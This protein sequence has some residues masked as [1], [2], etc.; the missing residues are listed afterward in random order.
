MLLHAFG[1]LCGFA[2][3]VF[4]AASR[5][6]RITLTIAVAAAILT[7]VLLPAGTLPDPVWGALAALIAAGLLLWR[8]DLTG[9]A[10]A[11]SGVA[12]AAWMSLLT[13][14]GVP[15]LLSAVAVLALAA[16]AF[17]LRWRSST[18]APRHLVEE[19]LLICAAFAIVTA[20]W[21]AVSAGYRSAMVFTAQ[22]VTAPP[23]AAAPWALQLSLGLLV[24]G[25]LYALWKRR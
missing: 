1:I 17:A 23:S 13:A 3:V 9:L 8:P 19:A 12:A 24:L 7:W 10:A 21:P 18:F 11:G 2:L 20:C 16:A 6:G 5:P 14:Q 22:R 15:W 4:A 25:G